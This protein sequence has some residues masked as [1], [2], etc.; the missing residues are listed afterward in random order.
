MKIVPSDVIPFL[1]RV[2]LICFSLVMRN[3]MTDDY[4][5]LVGDIMYPKSSYE[6]FPEEQKVL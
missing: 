3:S 6:T 5:D 1:L 2:L 4:M